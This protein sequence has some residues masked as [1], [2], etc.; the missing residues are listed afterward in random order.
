MDNASTP[1]APTRTLELNEFDDRLTRV[2]KNLS[3][4]EWSART[5]DDFLQWWTYTSWYIAEMRKPQVLR[6]I[7]VWGKERSASGWQYFNEAAERTTGRP[8]LI[9][10]R[11]DS[12]I[13]HPKKNGTTGLA[14]HPLSEKCLKISRIRGI[15]QPT[16]QEGFRA[17][18]LPEILPD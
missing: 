12:D 4:Y 5:N 16:I 11:C 18:V 8:K 17:G 3:L 6:K 1:A 2:G 7:P 15:A 9:C 10:Q 13:G 14:S